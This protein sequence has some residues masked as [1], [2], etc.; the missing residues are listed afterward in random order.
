MPKKKKNFVL[1][2]NVLMKYP[3]SIYGFDDNTVIVTATTI[4]E[5]DTL[6]TAKGET[7]YQARQALEKI[8]KL[9]I[10]AKEEKERLS[11]GVKINN[12]R[13]IFRIEND[14]VSEDSLPEGW[15]LTKGDNR[16]I[17]VCK[18]LKAIL[19]TEDRAM[20]IKADELN[21]P[22]ENYKNAEVEI[23]GEYT[24]RKELLLPRD[25]INT[26]MK[27]GNAD[28]GEYKEGLTENEYIIAHPMDNPEQSILMRYREGSFKRLVNASKF[29]KV[30]PQNAGQRFAFDALLSDDIPLVVLIGE[31]G[32]AKTFCSIVAAMYGYNQD[33]WDQI[34]ATRNNVEFDKGIGYLPG[35]E[36]EKVSPLLRGITDNLRTYLKIQGTDEQDLNATVNDYIETGRISVE[37]MGFMRGRSIT[38]SFLI[39]DE[40]QNATQKQVMGIVTRAGLH[41]KIVICGDPNQIDDVTLD[42]K[43]NGL[44]FTAEVMKGSVNCAIINFTDDECV[45]SPLAKDAAARMSHMA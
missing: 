34:I 25:L 10:L 24:G 45:R 7:G 2:T 13:G 8:D 31:A 38:N 11:D 42:K 9:R 33:K 37:S 18:A 1:D 17:S 16:I 35:D 14:H 41:T 6:K 19:V 40:A 36:Q 29:G 43:N 21:V 32:T 15:S 22:V 27:E 44:A 20:S 28:A 23:T 26:V 3:D 4:E 12:K 39:L 30:K 5:L